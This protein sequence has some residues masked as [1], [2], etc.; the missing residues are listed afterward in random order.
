[1]K[2]SMTTFL[3]ALI[4][5]YAAL[6][7]YLYINQRSLIYFPDTALPVLEGDAE[8]ISVTTT[9]GLK[10][11]GWY[12]PPANDQK[13]IIIHFQ[14]NAGNHSHR[15]WKANLLRQQG[16]GVL[17][18]GYRAYGGNPGEVSEQGLLKD[19]RAYMNFLKDKKNPL[20]VHGE[21]LGTGVATR[22]ASEYP[23]AGL[24]LESPYSSIADVAQSL[25]FYVPVGLLIKDRF[26]SVSAI[27][28]VT[29]PVLIIHGGQDQTIPVRFGRR[30]YEAAHQP[31]SFIS[32]PAAGHNDLYENGAALHVFEFLS[33]ISR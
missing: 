26:D 21:S 16:Y 1:M 29:A 14:G 28:N 22:M 7:T 23:V 3:I 25:Y 27:K 5:V 32:I 17:L 19:G 11:N 31:K 4:V 33:T 30:L 18:A 12:F 8:L 6:L 15:L 9:D 10:L 20:V 24:I 2:K 13:P